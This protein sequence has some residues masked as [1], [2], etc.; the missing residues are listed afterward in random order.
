MYFNGQGGLPLDAI[1]HLTEVFY[2][3]DKARPRAQ[4]GAGLGLTLCAQITQLHHD[5]IRFESAP[6]QGTSVIVS[7]RCNR[8][9]IGV[10][11]RYGFFHFGGSIQYQTV[12]LLMAV[13]NH[14]EL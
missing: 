2:R 4:G 5:G 12:G 11:K 1:A 8:T 7:L 9:A 10:Y 14:L 13:F 3:V 6:E